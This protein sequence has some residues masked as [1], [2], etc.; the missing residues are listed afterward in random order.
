VFLEEPVAF[1]F[2]V[3]D[4]GLRFLQDVGTLCTIVHDVITK[5]TVVFSVFFLCD[6]N[7]VWF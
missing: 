7:K 2:S 5:N 4:R 3:D 1:I 6:A